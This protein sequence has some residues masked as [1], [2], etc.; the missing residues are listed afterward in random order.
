MKPDLELLRE[1]LGEPVVGW[2]PAHERGYTKTRRWRVRTASGPRFVKE[3]R[4]EAALE[5]LRREA[6]VYHDVSGPFMAGFEGFAD[7]GDHA[8]LAL[9]LLDRSYW[10][11]PYPDDTSPLFAALEQLAATRTPAGLPERTTP[12]SRWEQVAADPGP[13]LALGV[14]S[15]E[16]LEQSL[17]ALTAAESRAAVSGDDLLHNDVYSGNVCFDGQQAILFDWGAAARG[18]RHLDT[19]FALVSVR[20]EGGRAPPVDLPGEAELMAW[21][22]GGFAVGATS[23]LPDWAPPGSTLRA[24]Q[25]GDLVGA[26]RCAA[27]ALGLPPLP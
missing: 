6:V 15:D 24:D 3:A 26:L 19:A 21:I 4:D 5:M 18:N 23:P 13:L 1:A 14:C 22:A 9:E 11:P 25:V 8:C 10:P 16:W 27:E 20:V 12:A 17:D 7:A 2:A